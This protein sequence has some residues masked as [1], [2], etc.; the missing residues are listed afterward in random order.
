M[1]PF[2]EEGS[3]LVIKE[4]MDQK[5]ISKYSALSA[6]YVAIGPQLNLGD[7]SQSILWEAT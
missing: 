2:E 5:T 4:A 3:I 6:D 1:N 7:A